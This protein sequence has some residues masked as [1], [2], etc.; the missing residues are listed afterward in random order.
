MHTTLASSVIVCTIVS[1]VMQFKVEVWIIAA[2]YIGYLV[3]AIVA[4]VLLG[5]EDVTNGVIEFSYQVVFVTS[6]LHFGFTLYGFTRQGYEPYP[7]EPK[8]LFLYG[9]LTMAAALGSTMAAYVLDY[10]N[11]TPMVIG[12]A[13]AATTQ[14]LCAWKSYNLIKDVHTKQRDPKTGE[15][16]A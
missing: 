6:A 3:S 4:L 10:N 16:L 9:D 8:W 13:T 11:L 15:L 7:V 2:A 1:F 12:N 5:M 14:M